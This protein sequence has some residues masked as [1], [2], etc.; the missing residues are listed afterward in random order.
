MKRFYSAVLIGVAV[1]TFIGC[2]YEDVQSDSNAI[3][4]QTQQPTPS[5][6]FTLPEPLVVNEPTMDGGLRSA[7]SLPIEGECSFEQ[8]RQ[9][10]VGDI[11]YL[12]PVYAVSSLSTD[13]PYLHG[14]GSL[15]TVSWS[16]DTYSDLTH[17][18]FGVENAPA[19]IFEITRESFESLMYANPPL[20]GAVAGLGLMPTTDAFFV[21]SRDCIPLGGIK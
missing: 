14:E 5:R 7:N 6:E 21:T 18:V 20:K 3:V 9:S 1:L 12:G 16:Q 15:L 19:K 2:T 10:P 17:Y 4:V 13:M 8:A 11:R